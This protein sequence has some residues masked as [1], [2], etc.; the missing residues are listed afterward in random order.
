MTV[1]KNDSRRR[2]D[3][4]DSYIFA[5][6]GSDVCSSD[7]RASDKLRCLCNSQKNYEKIYSK[8]KN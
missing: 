4:K 2:T 7:V 5:D 8:E 6:I 3:E 1:K